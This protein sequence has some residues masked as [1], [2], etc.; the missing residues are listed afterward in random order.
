MI[1]IFTMGK[2][3]SGLLLLGLNLRAISAVKN[4]FPVNMCA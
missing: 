4:N 1:S 3:L 2:S